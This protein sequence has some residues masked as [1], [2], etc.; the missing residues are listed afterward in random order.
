[1][2]EIDLIKSGDFTDHA[3]GKDKYLSAR[4]FE[5]LPHMYGEKGRFLVDF[6]TYFRWVDDIADSDSIPIDDRLE[7]ISRQKRLI[8]GEPIEDERCPIERYHDRINFHMFP[9]NIQE[10]IKKQFYIIAHSIH[11]DISNY[12]YYARTRRE[13]RQ[14][15]LRI[16]LPYAE[17]VSQVLNEKKINTTDKFANLLDSWTYLGG[18]LHLPKELGEEKIIKIGFSQDE[19]KKV[20][21]IDSETGRLEEIQEIYSPERYRREWQNSLKVF[22]KNCGSF[23][24]LDMPLYQKCISFLYLSIRQPIRLPGLFEEVE[25]ILQRQKSEPFTMTSS[26]VNVG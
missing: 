11:A 10:S 12:G 22:Q 19:A 17:I 7:F 14:N 9:E 3:P 20:N 15:N 4:V 24:N 25:D 21:S 2:S 23:T 5:I 1:M 26:P 6:Y 13:I 16:M 8:L 18:L